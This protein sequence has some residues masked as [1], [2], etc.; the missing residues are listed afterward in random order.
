M[1]SPNR[2]K[3]DECRSAEMILQELDRIAPVRF[4]SRE[5]ELI[6]AGVE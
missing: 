2:C 4:V 5:R 1:S 6:S 3:C